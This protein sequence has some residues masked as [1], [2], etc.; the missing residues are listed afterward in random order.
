MDN[1]SSS[2]RFE[3]F[4]MGLRVLVVDDDLTW[5]KILEK[6]LR[7][8]FY[9]VTTCCK[10]R[11]ALDLL[12]EKKDKFDIVISDVNMPDMDGFKLLEHVGLEMDLPVIMMS[13]DGETSRVMKGV[14]HGA[15]DYLLKPIR[16]KELRNIWQHVYRKRVVEV[17]D[18]EI[19]DI[20]EEIYILRSGF[21]H[22]DDRLF[23]T[24][25]EMT[26]SSSSSSRKRDAREFGDLELCDPAA[27]K[28]AR[29]I[30]SVDLH[31]KF[32]NAVDQIGFHKVG[33]KKI[34]DLMNVPGLTR[35]NIASHLQKYRMYLGRLQ[36]Q[37]ETRALSSNI[38]SDLS[39]EDH[40]QSIDC[41]N[42]LQFTQNTEANSCG[43]NPHKFLEKVMLQDAQKSDPKNPDFFL[44][45]DSNGGVNAADTTHP[46]KTNGGPRPAPLLHFKGMSPGADH[47]QAHPTLS[48]QQLWHDS[49]PLRQFMRYPKHD[50]EPFSLLDDYSLPAPTHEPRVSPWHSQCPPSLVSISSSNEKEEPDF[51]VKSRKVQN[52]NNTSSV[53]IQVEHGAVNSKE[54]GGIYEHNRS[55]DWIPPQ[56]KLNTGTEPELIALSED[57]NMYSVQGVDFNGSEMQPHNNECAASLTHLQSNW[58]DELEYSCEYLYDS[59]DYPLLDEC[60]FA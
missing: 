19:Q 21:E 27:A 23:M 5:L 50:H 31:Q 22:F 17:K 2:S 1:P 59:L 52:L 38:Q 14:Q 58:Y 10:A 39:P 53:S 36:K 25:I 15:C 47:K 24:S 7:K 41:Q 48:K 3:S 46:Q 30:W 26:S 49:L 18:M 6:M 9:E 60:L 34:L 55:H 20:N 44:G 37:Q 40:S 28:K 29:V 33:P 12:R 54:F 35:E 56:T 8:C 13:V 45:K 11:A 4:P 51:V 42:P 32:V 43:N 57:T 16:M